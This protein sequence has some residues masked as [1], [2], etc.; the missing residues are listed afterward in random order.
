MKN[1]PNNR[2]ST[3]DLKRDGKL[4]QF[5]EVGLCLRNFLNGE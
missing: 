1:F 2:I 3:V 4:K 5:R